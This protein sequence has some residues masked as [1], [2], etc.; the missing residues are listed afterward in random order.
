MRG[1]NISNLRFRAR[2]AP[3]GGGCEGAIL[4]VQAMGPETGGQ[5]AARPMALRARRIRRESLSRGRQTK[6]R[7][8]TQGIGHA[9]GRR[10]RLVG[11]AGSRAKGRKKEK[12]RSKRPIK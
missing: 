3:G 12:E 4:R 8:G 11:S 5:A 10:A 6:K 1:A 2:W 9:V 7:L